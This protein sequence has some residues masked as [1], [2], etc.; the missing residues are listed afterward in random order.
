M[1]TVII[2][3]AGLRLWQLDVLPPGLF[4][5][6]AYNG[7]DANRVIA[8]LS[9]PIFF[10]GNNA[11]EPLFIYLQALSVAFLGPTPFALRITSAMIGIATVPIIYFAARV[12]L[13]LDNE[14]N[15]R[16]TVDAKLLP[17]FALI[18]AAGVAVSYWHLSLSWLGFRAALLVPVSALAVAFF[19]RAWTRMR[20]RDYIW[21]GVWFG[22]AFYTYTSACALPLVVLCFVSIELVIRI[23][24]R[25]S[26]HGQL[27][28]PWHRHLKGLLLMAVVTGLIVL[29]LVVAIGK[30]P[31]LLSARTEDVNIFT[32]SQQKMSGLPAERLFH[33][34]IAVVRNFYDQGDQSMRHNLP[35]RP[36]N[37]P[38]LAVL[39]TLGWVSAVWQ[40]RQ[41]RNRLLLIWLAV[42]LMPTVLSTEAPHSLRSTGALPAVAMFYAVGAQA[43]YSVWITLKR[44]R[45]LQSSVVP[46]TVSDPRVSSAPGVSAGDILG[47][48]A[49]ASQRWLDNQ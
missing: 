22:V 43:S 36:V 40:I 46:E 9:R 48:V 18:A 39:F 41:S 32:V 38:L 24:R 15:D 49:A 34:V 11:R 45:G 30:D 28:R 26:S 7:L 13:P 31:L 20:W 35:G 37:D 10:A 44:R 1:I 42:M 3:A 6:E 21:A 8:G 47:H 4:F 23:A 5:D 16:L 2:L 14:Q 33:N 25:R 17:W 12:I 29:P 27:G 19:W